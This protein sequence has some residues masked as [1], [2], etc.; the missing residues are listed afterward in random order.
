MTWLAGL[1]LMA[2]GLVHAGI[3]CTPFDPAKAPFDPRHSWLAERLGLAG[4]ARGLSVALAL[5]AAVL[6]LASGA[7]VL[8]GTAWAG[9]AAVTAAAVSLLLTALVFNRWLS[10]NVLINAAIITAVLGNW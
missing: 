2:H 8:A 4:P 9:A 6:F 10:L 5:A 7:A 1:F 3:W